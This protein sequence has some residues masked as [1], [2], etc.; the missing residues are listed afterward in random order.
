MK[1]SISRIAILFVLS[2]IGII[3]FPSHAD[4]GILHT[5][6]AAGKAIY[7]ETGHMAK[8]VGKD[9]FGWIY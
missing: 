1:K 2:G 5:L 8:S 9:L 3:A 7:H 6:G 4:A